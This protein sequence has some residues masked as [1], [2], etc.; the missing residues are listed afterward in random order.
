MIILNKDSREYHIN[1][2]SHID[3]NDRQKGYKIGIPVGL[4]PGKNPISD[5]I[6]AELK[7]SEWF[8]I[9]QKEG[10]LEICAEIMPPKKTKTGTEQPP[11]EDFTPLM[12]KKKQKVE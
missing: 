5:D 3:K 12:E 10:I 6:L 8:S 1:T 11:T 2:G 9:L 4:L 7:K